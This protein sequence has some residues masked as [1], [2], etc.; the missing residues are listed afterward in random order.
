MAGAIAYEEQRRR[1]VAENRRKLEELRRHP[2]SAASRA[3]P[4]P[5]PRPVR[6]IL[7]LLLPCH[8][9]PVSSS[10]L[11]YDDWPAASVPQKRKAPGPG[12]LRA[13]PPPLWFFLRPI[14]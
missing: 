10:R 13:R 14:F 6:Q 8:R 12:P 5:N 1:Q 11:L 3:T 7:P 4:N 2:R 9:S